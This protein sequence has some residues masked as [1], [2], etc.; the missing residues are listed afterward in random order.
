MIKNVVFDIGNVLMTFQPVVYFNSYFQNEEKTMRL[1][2]QIFADDAWAKYDQGILFME[3]LKEYYTKTYPDDKEDLLYILDHWLELMGPI[4]E[5]FQL[6]QDLR[7]EDYGIY[8]LSNISKDSADYLKATQPFFGYADGAVL[9]YEEKINKPD[10]RIFQILLERYDLKAEETLFLDDNLTNVEAAK[11]RGIH[12][13][14]V[15]SV[16]SMV[17]EVTRILKERGQEC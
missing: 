16:S 6:M 13:L 11:C 15:V 12:A 3:D 9:S 2:T 4:P 14:Q 17:Q 1:C 7:M 10:H 8:L 5:A